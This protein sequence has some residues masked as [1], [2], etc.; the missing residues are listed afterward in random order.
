MVI[1]SVWIRVSSILVIMKIL[2]RKLCATTDRFVRMII[3]PHRG[4][5]TW[6]SKLHRFIAYTLCITLVIYS[7]LHLKTRSVLHLNS[8]LNKFSSYRD[9]YGPT[10]LQPVPQLCTCIM[11]YIQYVFDIHFGSHNTLLSS[12]THFRTSICICWGPRIF[13]YPYSIWIAPVFSPCSRIIFHLCISSK[14]TDSASQ[15]SNFW[16]AKL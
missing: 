15:Q 11:P 16:S 8:S 14:L 2:H 12:V 3:F 6:S 7:T 9:C 1:W 4:T 13:L 5:F 10:W